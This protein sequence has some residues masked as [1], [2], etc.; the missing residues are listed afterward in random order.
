MISLHSITAENFLSLERV[1]VELRD[2]NVLVGPNAAGKTNLLRV[3]QFLGD[4]A[5]LDLGPAIERH[6]GFS[7][8]LFRGKQRAARRIRL[9]IEACVTRFASA[10][11]RDA[12]ALTFWQSKNALQRRE[13]FRFKRTKGR[14]RRITISGG[15]VEIVDD[16]ST[17]QRELAAGSA[18]LS[19][20][21]RLGEKEGAPQV[22]ELAKLFE[23]FRVF[24][25]DVNAARRPAPRG[26]HDH[27]LLP[28]ASNLAAFLAWLAE[29]DEEVFQLL[30][31]D[32]CYIV[33][34][35]R[36]VHLVPVGGSARGVA[37]EL[38][39]AALEGRTALAAASFGTIR[40]LALLAMLHDPN[41]PR[42]TCVEEIDH[43]LHPYALERIVERLRGAT[44]R[45]Q[46]IVATHSPA[47]VNR[48]DPAELIVCERDVQTG[49]S[50]IPAIDRD[51]IELLARGDE[52]RLGELWF[53]G[54]L[55]GV[56]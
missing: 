28:D 11:A 40:A 27:L 30:R 43:G 48:L 1:S 37:I 32:L 51:E 29:D 21:R 20:L 15:K 6:G 25:V 14:G 8:L 55:G 17:R 5:R 7:S 50:K 44:R 52:L 42:L 16:A 54:S 41:P 19:T 23:T 22:R 35:L 31:E 49:A 39:E 47:L 36:D 4:A 38:E 24:E 18:G 53:S 34:G 56:L 13:E 46:L 26:E 12:Y 3:I 45:T 10:A 33:P 2:L 9:G